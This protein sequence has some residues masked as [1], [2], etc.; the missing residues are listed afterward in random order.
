MA[1][2]GTLTLRQAVEGVPNAS[3][4]DSD[5]GL[6]T[7]EEIVSQWDSGELNQPVTWGEDETGTNVIRVA[8]EGGSGKILL[9]MEPA[10][11]WDIPSPP[12][13]EP[14]D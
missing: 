6:W 11:G 3:W 2:T 1:Q 10:T 9:T 14:A 5:G 4:S 8:T 13:A 12:A 7:T